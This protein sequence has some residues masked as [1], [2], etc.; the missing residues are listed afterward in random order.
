MP[1][2]VHEHVGA[3]VYVQPAHVPAQHAE[4]VFLAVLVKLAAAIV[5]S[6]KA[7]LRGC[8]LF[9]CLQVDGQPGRGRSMPPWCQLL[10]LRLAPLSQ[11]WK[12][13]RSGSR[14]YR[15]TTPCRSPLA[16]SPCLSLSLSLRGEGSGRRSG[17]FPA[18][19]FAHLHLLAG[20]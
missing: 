12:C 10:S 2:H 9:R 4:V 7:A 1:G 8:Q 19:R 14:P 16:P 20:R 13:E 17:P 11:H 6:A 15:S 18:R 5:L 3:S